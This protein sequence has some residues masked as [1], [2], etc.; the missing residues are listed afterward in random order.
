VSV[1]GARPN[2]DGSR[3]LF[4]EEN[5]TVLVFR[6][7]AVIRLTATVTAG[8]LLFV[9]N[10]K[11]NQ[12]VVCQVVHKRSVP[13]NACYVELQFTEEKADFWGVAFP[14]EKK[15]GSE[16]QVKEPVNA[17]ESAAKDARAP[18][19]PQSAED[20]DRLKKE[21]EALRQH[22]QELEKKNAGKP[23]ANTTAE[24]VL[25]FAGMGLA[26]P[27][28]GPSGSK[29]QTE[30]PLMPAAAEKKEAARPVVGMA[31][32]IGKTAGGDAAAGAKDPAEE[33][34]PKPELDFSKMPGAVQTGGAAPGV[35]HSARAVKLKKVLVPLLGVLAVVLA[36]SAWNGKMWMYLPFGKKMT[37]A[38]GPVKTVKPMAAR[39]AAGAPG[40]ATAKGGAAK[41]AAT[42][43]GGTGA[44][45]AS[46]P[47]AQNV[48]DG[49]ADG[50]TEETKTGSV[51]SEEARQP[52]AAKEKPGKKKGATGAGTATGGDTGEIPSN[53]GAEQPAK[54][55]KAANPVYPPD[56]MRSFITGDVKV[57]AVV[58]ADGH[59]GDVKV[60]SGPR[61]L[62]E[63]AV[64]ALKKYQYAAA[65]RGGKAVASKVTETVKFWFNP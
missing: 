2:S 63:A 37:A 27:G 46:G 32:P 26:K 25:K 11:S 6:D 52:V 51:E 43:S 58:E 12:E 44:A 38:V 57:E 23:G 7:G 54:L 19:G 20:V 55:L 45:G 15:G 29:P 35:L 33:L 1:T 41:G 10:K 9:T 22:V 62:R 49:S 28:E 21:I 31:L 65:K 8:Q 17:E 48:G 36:W 42:V 61:A 16:I 53:D 3:D 5:V 24:E 18:V 30:A 4:T 13:P 39:P 56:A 14:D 59:V 60:I 34:L 40:S 50:N 47:V 64:E